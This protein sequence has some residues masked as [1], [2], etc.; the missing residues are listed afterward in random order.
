MIP[1]SDILSP[2]TPQASYHLASVPSGAVGAVLASIVSRDRQAQQCIYVASHLS[3]AHN[4]AEAV[5]FYS[6]QQIETELFPAWDCAP[7]DRSSPSASIQAER[8][9]MLHQWAH[10]DACTSSPTLVIVPINALLQWIPAPEYY[11]ALTSRTLS[12][13]MQIK[14]EQL[15]RELVDLGFNH[16]DMVFNPGDFVRRGGVLDVFPAGEAQP[17]RLDFFGDTLESLT[18]FD[19]LTQ[20]RDAALSRC[21]LSP[22]REIILHEQNVEYFR[23]KYRENFGLALS[24]DSLYA[25]VSAQHPHPG[26]EHWLPLFYSNMGWLGAYFPQPLFIIGKGS[27]QSGFDKLS[28]IT[29]YFAMRAQHYEDLAARIP[30]R[31]RDDMLAECYKPLPPA[32]LYPDQAQL[33]AYLAKQRLIALEP[34]SEIDLKNQSINWKNVDTFITQRALEGQSGVMQALREKAENDWKGKVKIIAM[35]R[36]KEQLSAQLEQAG[37]T[38]RACNSLAEAKKHAPHVLY[39]VEQLNHQGFVGDSVVVVHENDLLGTSDV[40]RM[41]RKK[42]NAQILF[43]V[44][45]LSVGDLVIHLEHGVGRYQ[46]LSTVNSG[47]QQQECLKIAYAD[48]GMLYVP[49]VNI[50]Q[51]SL[52]GEA[53]AEKR[54]LDRLGSAQW[55]ARKARVRK[56]IKDIAE[57]L[58]ALA[59]KRQAIMIKPTVID[60]EAYHR[61]KTQVN[62]ELTEDQQNAIDDV[63]EDIQRGNPM[64]RLICGDVGFGKTEIAMHGIFLVAQNGGQVALLA[65]T[66]L[67]AAQH[68]RTVRQRMQGFGFRIALRS[69]SNSAKEAAQIDAALAKGEIDIVV[70]THALL[71]PKIS[72]NHLG[73]VVIDEEQ[74]FGVGQKEH[75]KALRAEIHVLSL[76]ATPIPRTLNMALSGVRDL[77]VIATPPVDR[78]A[79]RTILEPYDELS[80]ERALMREKERQGQSY[81]VTPRIKFL[82]QIEDFLSRRMPSLRFAT[83]H[84]RMKQFALDQAMQAFVDGDIDVLVAT[85]IIESGIDVASAN[86]M[87]VHRPDLFGLSQLYQIRGRIG[88]S[89]VRANC[90]LCLPKRGEIHTNAVQRLQLLQTLDT[91]GAGF[92]LAHHDMDLRG[93]GNLVGA[94]QSGHINEVGIE[95]YHHMLSEAITALKQGEEWDAEQLIKRDQLSN[96]EINLGVSA[97]L[98]EAYV[99]DLATRLSLYRRLARIETSAELCD[100]REELQDRFG[101]LPEV[102][103]NLLQLFDIKLQAKKLYINKIDVGPQGLSIKFYDNHFTAS[104]KLI[105]LLI[106]QPEKYRLTPEEKLQYLAPVFAQDDQRIAETSKFLSSLSALQQE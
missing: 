49:V 60:W 91:L 81:F 98:P 50:E 57:G 59:A 106:T 89:H 58:I 2:K 44:N 67:L 26:M 80:I 25:A 24:Q 84:G 69:R 71:N 3:D 56:R 100:M 53:D 30:S 20:R 105:N 33:W 104:E 5:R 54:P 31:A 74:R 32:Q 9:R 48:G 47:Q 21:V 27:L 62:F 85:S 12:A 79:I 73:L 102:S 23:Q 77:S 45:N 17:I 13:G 64:D 1:T 96:I 78:L 66:T 19:P 88:R 68:Y 36:R 37:F 72:F 10:R 95:L 55:Q 16:V 51:I 75:L 70:G 18:Q 52:Y 103:E 61:F 46:G 14:P 28:D 82:A 97:H 90:Y 38:L 15:A 29:S 40:A 94:E 83:V 7:Y 22:C 65:P 6:N 43:E 101:T 41:K 34:I 86:T 39:V 4:I 63:L 76:S 42:K 93:A 8:A 87:I 11:R 99:A 35:P 92:T